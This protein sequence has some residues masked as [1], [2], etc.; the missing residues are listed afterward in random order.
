MYKKGC[1]GT[2]H[3]RQGF[4]GQRVQWYNGKTGDRRQGVIDK[5]PSLEG[6]G[7]VNKGLA[8]LRSCKTLLQP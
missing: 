6:W 5:L 4:G 3:L 2:N 1:N 8:A 7:W